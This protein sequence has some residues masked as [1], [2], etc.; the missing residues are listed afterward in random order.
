MDEIIVSFINYFG[1]LINELD[2]FVLFGS[3][4]FLSAI[5]VT[6]IISLVLSTLISKGHI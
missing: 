6:T 2:S 4:S 1:N 3:V 5:I